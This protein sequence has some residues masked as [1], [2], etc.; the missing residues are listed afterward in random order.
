MS[1]FGRLPEFAAS[2][3]EK[4]AIVARGSFHRTFFPK[5]AGVISCP[6]TSSLSL[7]VSVFSI[8]FAGFWVLFE[9]LLI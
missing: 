6:T 3:G 7:S 8:I 1:E 2:G 5:R 9:V 4:E